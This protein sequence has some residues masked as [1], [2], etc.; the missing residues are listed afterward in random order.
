MD[1]E[2]FGFAKA[3]C[4]YVIDKEY[5]NQLSNQKTDRYSTKSH[6]KSID[7]VGYRRKSSKNQPI[8]N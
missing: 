3:N 4:D 1:G 8:P 7:L 6:L 2:Y 5:V